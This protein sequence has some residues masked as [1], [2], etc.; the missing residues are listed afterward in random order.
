MI[1][2][3]LLMGS[4]LLNIGNGVV[5]GQGRITTVLMEVHNGKFW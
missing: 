5:V 2:V 3:G 4:F 1:S